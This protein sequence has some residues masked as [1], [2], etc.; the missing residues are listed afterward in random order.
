MTDEAMKPAAAAHDRRHDDPQVSASDP[1]RLHP[2]RVKNFAAF[3]DRSPEI[4]RRAWRTFGAFSSHLAENGAQ[5]PILNHTV[6]ALRFFF[7]VT[8]KRHD[9]VEHNDVHPRAAQCRWCSVPREV[10]RLLKGNAAPAQ[11]QGGAE[12]G[13]WGGPARAIRPACICGIRKSTAGYTPYSAARDRWNRPV[14]HPVR[15]MV[16]E[17]SAAATATASMRR[18][19]LTIFPGWWCDRISRRAFPRLRTG[20]RPRAGRQLWTRTDGAAA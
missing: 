2:H 20:S 14:S 11:V 8:L 7:R 16:P 12:R 4:S 10:A 18:R 6:S 15:T 17:S 13:L 5:A 3:V 1:A 9:I 19:A